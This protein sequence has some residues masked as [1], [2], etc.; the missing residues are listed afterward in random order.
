MKSFALSGAALGTALVWSFFLISAATAKAIARGTPTVA[1]L[2]PIVGTTDTVHI[3]SLSSTPW[4]W[5]TADTSSESFSMTWSYFSGFEPAPTSFPDV[6][7]TSRQF[8]ISPLGSTDYPTP[9]VFAPRPTKRAVVTPTS[10]TS[11][12]DGDVWSWSDLPKSS[13]ITDTWSSI[14]DSIIASW[15][16]DTVSPPSEVWTT[17]TSTAASDDTTVFTTTTVVK[18]MTRHKSSA[19]TG[20]NTFT[21]PGPVETRQAR[22]E[23][24]NPSVYKKVVTTKTI[25]ASIPDRKHVRNEIT[26]P[27]SFITRQARAKETTSGVPKK[28]CV[29]APVCGSDRKTLTTTPGLKMTRISTSSCVER[30]TTC[31]IDG[32]LNPSDEY[33]GRDCICVCK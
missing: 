4:V 23:V 26:A 1:P 17:T 12:D 33:C 20:S 16:G 2:I 27:G 7:S 19:Q 3:P 30:G 31:A 15:L 13:A 6:P 24:T 5:P 29:M 22:A 14:F 25:T 8:V 18:T 28:G 9:P 10:I 21:G 32:E 11:I